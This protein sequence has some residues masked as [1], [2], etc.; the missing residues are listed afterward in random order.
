MNLA[1]VILYIP[2]AFLSINDELFSQIIWLGPL[3]LTCIVFNIALCRIRSTIRS[4]R[5]AQSNEKLALIHFLNIVIYTVLAFCVRIFEWKSNTYSKLSEHLENQYNYFY[6]RVIFGYFLISQNAFAL[7]LDL[8][9][10][11]LILKFTNEKQ[12]KSE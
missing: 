4:I 7:Y 12:N 5:I 6:Y 1:V 11:Y 10:L 8:F 3:L 2:G 9:V